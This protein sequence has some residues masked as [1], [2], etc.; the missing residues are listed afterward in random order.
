M[1]NRHSVALQ[2]QFNCV[3]IVLK[4]LV[5]ASRSFYDRLERFLLQSALYFFDLIVLL[6]LSHSVTWRSVTFHVPLLPLHHHPLSHTNTQHSITLQ[7]NSSQ[8]RP[9]PVRNKH[10]ILPLTSSDKYRIFHIQHHKLTIV[11]NF[12]RLCNSFFLYQIKSNQTPNVFKF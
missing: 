3:S 8:Y 1:S 9:R 2:S 6:Q 10:T 7:R 11:T 5:I 4:A 12:E